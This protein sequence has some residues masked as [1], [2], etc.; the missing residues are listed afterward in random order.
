MTMPA[1]AKPRSTASSRSLSALSH[2]DSGGKMCV[3]ACLWSRPPGSKRCATLV[4]RP[5][6]RT[7]CEPARI[8][9]RRCRASAAKRSRYCGVYSS[10]RPRSASD[11]SFH[12]GNE[13]NSSIVKSS[14]RSTRSAPRAPSSSS[15]ACS[16]NSAKLPTGRS[17]N[18]QAAIESV[19]AIAETS[20]TLTH[21]PGSRTILGHALLL[22]GCGLRG[23]A[24]ALGDD[25]ERHRQLV[26]DL[27]RA[28]SH[29]D[30]RH[31]EVALLD[32]GLALGGQRVALNRDR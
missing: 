24:P 23:G 6:S 26:L 32:G 7:R 19:C 25:R 20:A 9:C 3:F 17:A 13:A 31:A 21:N 4:V 1:R 15:R 14:G 30:R 8:T 27:D 16:A 22:L 10:I 12:P 2:A 29:R 11:A 5:P 28:T 18:W